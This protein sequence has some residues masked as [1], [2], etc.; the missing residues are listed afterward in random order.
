MNFSEATKA[1]KEGKKIR[2]KSWDRFTNIAKEEN[3]GQDEIFAYAQMAVPYFYDNNI[4]LSDDW[5][6]VDAQGATID[7][8][9][10]VEMLKKRFKVRLK[11]WPKHQYIELSENGRELVLRK[12]SQHVFQPDFECFSAIDWEIFE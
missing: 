11:H 1:L 5:E 2:R 6:V 12:M 4:I 8:P 3:E 9:D 10:A 7:F